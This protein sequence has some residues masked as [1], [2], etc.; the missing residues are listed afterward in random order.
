MEQWGKIFELSF[1]AGETIV[2]IAENFPDEFFAEVWQ[3][4]P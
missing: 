4:F 1:G 2:L 3:G